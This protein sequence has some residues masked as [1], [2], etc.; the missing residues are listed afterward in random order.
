[1]IIPIAPYR[2]GPTKEHQPYSFTEE[3][4]RGKLA[5]LGPRIYSPLY[6]GS[7]IDGGER[8]FAP[9]TWEVIE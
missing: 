1:M 5:D 3:G 7:P 2:S 9:E 8:M 6:M 4:F